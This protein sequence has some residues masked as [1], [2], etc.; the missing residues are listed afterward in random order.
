MRNLRFM[1]KQQIH[2]LKWLSLLAGAFLSVV[3]PLLLLRVDVNSDLAFMILAPGSL[4]MSP[5]HNVLPALVVTVVFDAIIY[6][7]VAYSI[8]RLVIKILEGKH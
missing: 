2:A 4:L 3:V 1:T 8:A 6:C 5:V 7:A